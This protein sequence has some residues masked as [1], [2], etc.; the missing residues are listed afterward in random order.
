MVLC[1]FISFQR[2]LK[3]MIDVDIKKHRGQW[4]TLAKAVD[5]VKPVRQFS[6]DSHCC[7]RF[8][9]QSSYDVAEFL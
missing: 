5:D 9:L 3:H 7:L 2:N 6:F 1:P 8:R 4:T